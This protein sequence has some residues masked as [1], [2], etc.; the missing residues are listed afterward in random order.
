M[1]QAGWQSD[2][3]KIVRRMD[4]DAIRVGTYDE[5]GTLHII[6]AEATISTALYRQGEFGTL[7]SEVTADGITTI[8]VHRSY[9]GGLDGEVYLDGI[10]RVEDTTAAI[11][12][13]DILTAAAGFYGEFDSVE[14]PNDEDWSW[15]IQDNQTLWLEHVPEP[16]T[17]SLLVL[18]GLSLLR[19]RKRGAC[20]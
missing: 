3:D 18:G 7:V 2:I 5:D 14:L 8:D 19:R 13:F 9:S 1:A 6:G 12:R 11:G 17:L 16:A 10:W 15:G 4:G 20:K